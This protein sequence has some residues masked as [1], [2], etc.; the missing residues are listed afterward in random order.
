MRQI[1]VAQAKKKKAGS[2]TISGIKGKGRKMKFT[3]TD[4]SGKTW[5]FK[6]SEKGLSRKTKINGEKAKAGQLKKGMV[7]S[8]SYYGKGGVVYSASCKG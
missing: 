6:A 4:A 2:L 5:N 7:C 1:K 8:V 3:F